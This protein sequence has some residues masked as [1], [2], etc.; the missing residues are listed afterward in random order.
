MEFG[1]FLKKLVSFEKL[2][3]G[4]LGEVEGGGVLCVVY[5]RCMLV[6]GNNEMTFYYVFCGEVLLLMRET[7]YALNCGSDVVTILV[8]G[9]SYGGVGRLY[10]KCVDGMAYVVS[11]NID[12]E[13][14]L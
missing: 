13:G 14:I 8:V 1:S 5:F 3:G 10:L 11:C 9:F 12:T 6:G 7:V 4:A 2:W